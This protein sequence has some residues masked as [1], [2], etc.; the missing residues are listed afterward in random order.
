MIEKRK[1][2]VLDFIPDYQINFIFT[3]CHIKL[4]HKSCAKLCKVYFKFHEASHLTQSC[5][6]FLKFSN[7]FH[8]LFFNM[9]RFSSCFQK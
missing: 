9:K 6:S 2:G 8:F 4:S 1:L 7:T 5:S 3:Y